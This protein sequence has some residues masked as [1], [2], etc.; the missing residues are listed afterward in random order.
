MTIRLDGDERDRIEGRDWPLFG[1]TMAGFDRL[2][3]FRSCIE[4]VL[5]DDVPGDIIETGVWRGGASIFAR[6]VL[7]SHGVDDR[8]V[9]L[10]DSF[11]G[12]PP[13]NAE[14]NP[15]DAGAI[16]HTADKL[17]ISLEEVQENFR[18]YGLLDDQVSFV[19]GWFS[20]TL[21]ALRSQTWSV[22]RLDGDMYESTMDGLTNLYD[23]L[24]AGG[25]LIVDDYDAID[26][27]RE[28]V[29]DFRNDQG[30]AAPIER[31]DWSGVYWRKPA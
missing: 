14:L 29:T 27:C 21:P 13:P 18:R 25:F 19:E 23:G 16:W 31:I 8:T 12:L 30:I 6:A 9:W 7:A 20:E 1:Q 10:A 22:I 15:A 28:A 3:N 4:T 11:Q 5:A 17:A 2:D 24:S 26:A